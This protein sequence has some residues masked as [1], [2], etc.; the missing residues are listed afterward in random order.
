MKVYKA[1]AVVEVIDEA[2]P[3]PAG[4]VVRL[5]LT[6]GKAGLLPFAYAQ[7]F[8]RGH[9][10]NGARVVADCAEFQCVPWSYHDD[11]SVRDAHVSGYC[12]VATPGRIDVAMKIGTPV[13]RPN[14]MRSA[15][16]DVQ[17]AIGGTRI[18]P[19]APEVIAVGP[20]ML[21]EKWTVEADAQVRV[22]YETRT[23]AHG[24]TEV[25][26]PCVENTGFSAATQTNRVL[27]LL[28][29]IGGV[30]TFAETVDVKHHTRI[31]L[32]RGSSWSYWIGTNPQVFPAHDGAYLCASES[33]PPYVVKAAT[34]PN[35][36]T[37]YAP[38]YVGEDGG[39]MP[40]TGYTPRIGILG[41]SN[42]F[43]LTTGGRKAWDYM[44]A[45][46]FSAGSYSVHLRDETTGEIPRFATYPTRTI[47][48]GSIPGGT[49]GTNGT[50]DIAHHPSLCYV[51]AKVT[52]WRWFIDE[53]LHWT[54]QNHFFQHSSI[55]QNEKGILR[56]DV[57]ANQDRGAGW[58]LRTLAQAISV[59]PSTHPLQP[60]LIYAWQSNMAYYRARFVDGTLDGGRYVNNL[61][62]IAPYSS[63]GTSPY[64]GIDVG[65]SA[66]WWGA[67]FMQA[68]LAQSIG[69]ALQMRLPVGT[70]AQD[71]TRAVFFQCSKLIVGLC[72]VGGATEWNWR[73]FGLYAM[74]F[75]KDGTKR[76][77]DVSNAWYANH[78]EAYAEYIKAKA[79]S[80]LDPAP[81]G[82]IKKHSLETDVNASDWSIG[83]LSYP[84]PSLVYAVMHQ[85]PGANAALARVMSSA[86]WPLIAASIN[87]PEWSGM[88]PPGFKHP[89]AP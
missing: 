50:H 34:I 10:P 22:V 60:D 26:V 30:T 6:F 89:G 28:V 32:M 35:V 55:R 24:Q 8:A 69:H 68:I 81:G 71:D 76:P 80:A 20:A 72:G 11:G 1:G 62:V 85:V 86:S 51:A 84:W 14:V 59:A 78:A 15:M 74:P 83:F 29:I 16:P 42:V 27:A 4:A 9:V 39:Y 43:Y 88:M 12:N 25:F 37:T 67:A 65:N 36:T 66:A 82:T 17:I 47:L 2:P 53:H 70:K 87:E 46:A 40:A 73:R 58:A 23:F 3:D 52:G 21:H 7:T 77:A 64:R 38:N 49:G 48:G 18:N 19:G 61:G 31:A 79:L 5:G 33:F 54:A 13:A 56:T 57:G 75:F 63:D 45:Q 41:R 44:I